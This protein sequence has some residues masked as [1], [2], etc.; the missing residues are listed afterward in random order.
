MVDQQTIAQLSGLE[1]SKKLLT[2]LTRQLFPDCEKLCNS[3]HKVVQLSTCVNKMKNTNQEL[4]PL[5][6]IGPSCQD[7]PWQL[8]DHTQQQGLELVAL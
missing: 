7:L 1:R 8:L 5:V 6:A 4:L 3:L 2:N